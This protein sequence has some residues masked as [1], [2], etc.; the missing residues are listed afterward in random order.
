MKLKFL[1]IFVVCSI[2]ILPV[3]SSIPVLSANP[4]MPSDVPEDH[5]IEG[6]PYVSQEMGVSCH[7]GVLT[8]ILQYYGINITEQELRHNTGSGFSV[9]YLSE[10]RLIISGIDSSNW[11]GDREFIASLYGLSYENW[12]SPSSLSGEKFWQ[13]YWFRIKQNISQNIPVW[14]WANPVYLKSI[15]STISET[16]Q[17]PERIWKNLPD[18]LF[19]IITEINKPFHAILIVGYNEKNNSICIHDPG[20][21]VTG[22]PQFGKYMW[23]NL[24]DYKNSI[25]D[26]SKDINCYN[27]FITFQKISKEPLNKTA[28]FKLSFKRNLQRMKGNISAYDKMW[29]DFDLG[30]NALK[31]LK[32][33]FEPGLKN[34]FAT[35][36]KYKFET[37]IIKR[38]YRAGIFLNNIGPKLVDLSMIE[39]M[40]SQ[41]HRITFEKQDI[42]KYL[43][44]V[45]DLINDANLSSMCRETSLLLSQEA[46][47]WNNLASYYT[48]F[49]KRGVFMSFP[50][51]VILINRMADSLDNIIAIEEAIIA[52]PT[53]N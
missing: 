30:I 48:K 24:S 22:Y 2:I 11:D 47:N 53:N 39:F 8:M 4:E 41:Y 40:V 6:A 23:M 7:Y 36:L 49:L 26:V 16:F 12:K 33:N 50:L 18:F 52:G 19:K 15:R 20:P 14:A 43:W 42:A 10:P 28:V 29:S 34:R 31:E 13:E 32:K 9:G 5:I 25:T 21:G 38:I 37:P 27:S 44:K 46:E 17:M 45:K 3:L 1:T 35:I 51:S